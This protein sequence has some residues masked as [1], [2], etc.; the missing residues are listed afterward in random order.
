[1]HE[2]EASVD[3][4]ADGLSLFGG[5]DEVLGEKNEVKVVEREGLQGKRLLEAL[6]YFFFGA[7]HQGTFSYVFG[8]LVP[9]LVTINAVLGEVG[10]GRKVETEAGIL[11]QTRS[12]PFCIALRCSCT[13]GA[14]DR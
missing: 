14:A 4:D 5:H 9:T 10:E 1:M 3:P 6:Y 7:N 13:V 11:I 2:V 12:S 8:S